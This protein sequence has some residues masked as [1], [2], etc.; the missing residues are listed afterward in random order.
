MSLKTHS[1]LKSTRTK[2]HMLGEHRCG[3]HSSHES[4]TVGMIAR[5]DG[6]RR[7]KAHS[8]PFVAVRV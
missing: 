8:L 1:E 3:E 2:L 5:D 6:P 7:S 4:G